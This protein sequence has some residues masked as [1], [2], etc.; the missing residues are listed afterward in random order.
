MNHI[1]WIPIVERPPSDRQ[2]VIVSRDNHLGWC[3]NFP[4][5]YL[6]SSDGDTPVWCELEVDEMRSA[7]ISIH[8]VQATDFWL[9]IPSEPPALN[10]VDGGYPA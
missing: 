4:A 3:R 1:P 5:T 10:V 2:P 9:A 8:D 6:V 7:T